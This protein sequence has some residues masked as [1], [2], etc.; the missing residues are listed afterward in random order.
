MAVL[1]ADREGV[2]EAS[3]VQIPI[4]K[5]L[6]QQMGSFRPVRRRFAGLFWII[7]LASNFLFPFFI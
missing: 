5:T 6:R 2:A 3:Q 1:I 4:G 7:R